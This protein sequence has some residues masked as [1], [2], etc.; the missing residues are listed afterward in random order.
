VGKV[1][2]EGE[3]FLK[4]RSIFLLGF[5]GSGK[6]TVGPL[7]ARV[8]GRPF[9]DLDLLIEERVGKTI[10]TIFLEEGEAGF[11]KYE[12]DALRKVASRECVVATGGGVVTREENWDI[13][14]KG[15]TVALMA[16]LEELERRLAGSQGRPLLK[17]DRDWRGLFQEREP[18]YKRASLVV[19][20][21]GLTP[22]EVVE[23]ILRGLEEGKP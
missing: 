9:V 20:T 1:P 6:S 15:F 23:A 14:K 19:D 5:M 16:S 17:G 7:L 10:G 22:L 13:L 3:D 4:G 2:G 18:L 12:S 21:T 11:R 8:L